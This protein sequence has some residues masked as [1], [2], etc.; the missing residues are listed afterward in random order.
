[1]FQEVWCDTEASDEW[2]EMMTF[3]N[4]EQNIDE[5]LI[6]YEERKKVTDELIKWTYDWIPKYSEIS[7]EVRRKCKEI[8]KYQQ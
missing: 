5:E 1:L 4:V 3:G 6:R 2:R 7:K 8:Q